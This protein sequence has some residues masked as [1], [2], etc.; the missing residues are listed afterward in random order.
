MAFDVVTEVDLPTTSHDESFQG[1]VTRNADNIRSV[2]RD[3]QN[4]H[5]Y[6]SFIAHPHLSPLILMLIIPYT[7]PLSLYRWLCACRSIRV[8]V[9]TDA[10]FTRAESENEQR[11]P[12]YFKSAVF[13][14]DDSQQLNL[15][16]IVADLNSKVEH[17]NSRG[18]GYVLDASRGSR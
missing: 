18:T 13:D 17:W 14:V 3:C 11:V 16:D 10:V 12:A 6:S 8:H 4:K 15:D 7:R 2:V 9:T 5:M 1:Y